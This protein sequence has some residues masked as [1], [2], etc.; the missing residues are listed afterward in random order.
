MTGSVEKFGVPRPTQQT[1]PPDNE[2]AKSHLR[3][4][5]HFIR[6]ALTRWDR[7]KILFGPLP[8]CLRNSF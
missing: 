7:S 3:L 8:S 6:P 2:A 4:L 1:V 5:R